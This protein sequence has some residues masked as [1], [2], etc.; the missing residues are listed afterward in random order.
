MRTLI[1]LLFISLNIQ[2]SQIKEAEQQSFTIPINY[3]ETYDF[4]EYLDSTW[5][6][7]IDPSILIN[8]VSQIESTRDKFIIN[9]FEGRKVVIINSDGSIFGVIDKKGKG[10][11][12]YKEVNA[13]DVFG[14]KI[15]VVAN[16]KKLMVFNLD[17]TFLHERPFENWV[18]KIRVLNDDFL[19]AFSEFDGFSEDRG[20]VRLETMDGSKYADYLSYD[21]SL[22]Q[23]SWGE[24]HINRYKNEFYFV[25]PLSAEVYCFEGSSKSVFRKFLFTDHDLQSIELDQNVE[26]QP[27]DIKD[28]IRVSFIAKT[29]DLLYLQFHGS[30]NEHYTMAYNHFTG[31]SFVFNTINSDLLLSTSPQKNFLGIITPFVGVHEDFVVTAFPADLISSLKDPYEDIEFNGR[32]NSLGEL[33]KYTDPNDNPILFFYRLKG[34]SK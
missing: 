28:Y 31:Q 10:P 20:Y 29:S 9:D 33:I 2:C 5:Y 23:I 12:E 19:L 27:L 1:F 8:E 21:N 4:H 11:G 6:L 3:K 26:H 34:K 25:P 24:P 14:D 22:S 7:K 32:E 15:Y 17:G 16:R 18:N 30:K 13:I